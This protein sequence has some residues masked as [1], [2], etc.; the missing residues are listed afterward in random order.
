MCIYKSP[1]HKVMKSLGKGDSYIP[2]SL[3]IPMDIHL[4]VTSAIYT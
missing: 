4:K 2:A 3:K 1:W